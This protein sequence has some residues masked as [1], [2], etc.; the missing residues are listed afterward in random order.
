MNSKN[1]G[2]NTMIRSN[3]F[4]PKDIDQFIKSQ[5]KAM[6]V[7]KTELMITA[8][9]ELKKAILRTQMKQYYSSEKNQQHEQGMANEWIPYFS[10]IIE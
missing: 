3:I 1:S 4:L 6:G 2:Q 8:V 10:E 5:S 7:T 9:K